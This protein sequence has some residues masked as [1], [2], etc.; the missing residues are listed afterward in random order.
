MCV[1]GRAA[2]LHGDSNPGLRLHTGLSLAV[3]FHYVSV[4]D[5]VEQRAAL[6]Q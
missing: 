2:T 3:T 6:E 4:S 5:T 1:C